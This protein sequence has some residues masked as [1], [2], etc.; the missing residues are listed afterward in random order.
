VLCDGGR[1]RA[2]PSVRDRH[3]GKRGVLERLGWQVHEVWSA[4]WWEDPAGVV[5]GILRAF[6]EARDASPGA[7]AP[8]PEVPEMERRPPAATPA[9]GGALKR[10]P[11]QEGYVLTVFADVAGL[12]PE[13]L[14]LPANRPLLRAQMRQVMQTESPVTRRLLKRRVAAAWGVS[15]I[16]SRIDRQLDEV[17]AELGYLRTTQASGDVLWMPGVSPE[18][19]QT[20][21]TPEEESARRDPEDL[22]APETAAA[23]EAV[24]RYS[25]SIT[26]DDLLRE[27]AEV[28]GYARRSA[29]LDEAL[30]EGIR[31]AAMF[32]R[33]RESGGRYRI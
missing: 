25:Y 14:S 30:R 7:A 28:F 6:G 8:A 31:M 23:T 33:V 22:P 16:G 27:L 11:G 29:G 2:T 13:G 24:V 1:F 18:G 20:F 10:L 9:P 3:A 12:E 4:E 26:E 5:D 21:R 17:I 15:R 19:M 32:G